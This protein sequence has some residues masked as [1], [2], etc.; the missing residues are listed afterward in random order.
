V[1][2]TASLDF[3]GLIVDSGLPVSIDEVIAAFLRFSSQCYPDP[4]HFLEG[5]GKELAWLIKGDTRRL[6]SILKK[7]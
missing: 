4:F 7:L 2:F 5:A 6:T 1:G 3:L